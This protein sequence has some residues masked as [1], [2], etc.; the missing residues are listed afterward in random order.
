MRS[1]IT[2]IALFL[3]I[4]SRPVLAVDTFVP[5]QLCD[6]LGASHMSAD[7]S[8][9]VVCG[10][11]IGDSIA[12]CTDGGCVWKAMSGG[13]ATFTKCQVKHIPAPTYPTCPAGW[14]DVHHYASG[15][16][17]SSSAPYTGTWVTTN[18]DSTWNYQSGDTG[19]AIATNS[20]TVC[21]K[22]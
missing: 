9:L 13:G 10:R 3:L 18:I 15:T 19:T 5:G 8:G 16:I 22:N 1:I 14:T 6:T 7:L 12:I 20:C 21:M 11:T 17:T 4:L 2:L